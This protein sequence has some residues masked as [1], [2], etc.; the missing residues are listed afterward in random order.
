VF[1]F[2]ET[3]WGILK[4]EGKSLQAMMKTLE[5]EE[6]P[7]AWMDQIQKCFENQTSK[8]ALQLVINKFNPEANV[9]K[10]LQSCIV[11]GILYNLNSTKRKQAIEVFQLIPMTDPDKLILD[12][13]KEKRN[14]FKSKAL[15]EKNRLDKL[16]EFL[17]KQREYFLIHPND[18]MPELNEYGQMF[19]TRCGY[20]KCKK[21]FSSHRDRWSHFEYSGSFLGI[22]DSNRFWIEGFHVTT[23]GYFNSHPKIDEDTFV[24]D[25]L[26]RLSY[27]PHLREH[28]EKWIRTVYKEYKALQRY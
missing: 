21:P 14:S 11:R 22:N 5:K 16:E 9:D 27:G 3:F 20:R 2:A 6:V 28:A 17:K 19:T 4:T 10:V 18:E 8:H 7:E 25:M 26:A 24:K 23:K 15:V 13:V 12:V 1:V